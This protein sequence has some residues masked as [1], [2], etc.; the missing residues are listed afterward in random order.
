MEQHPSSIRISPTAATVL[1]QEV[2]LSRR[3]CRLVPEPVTTN[4][5]NPKES[6]VISEEKC[7]RDGTARFLRNEEEEEEEDVGKKQNSSG[8]VQFRCSVVVGL[9]GQVF[10]LVKALLVMGRSSEFRKGRFTGRSSFSKYLVKL[11]ICVA[12]VTVLLAEGGGYVLAR[13]N[14]SNVVGGGSVG[15]EE[16][17]MVSFNNFK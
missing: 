9:I 13:P 6:G 15:S 8:H 1:E 7:I 14:R 5:A 11:G 3:A 2:N 12:V 4:G 16:A 10:L 17:A